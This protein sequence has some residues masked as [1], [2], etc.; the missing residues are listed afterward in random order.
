MI[1]KFA[2]IMGI[3]YLVAGISGFIPP[4]VS[5]PEEVHG[6]V[7]E[8]GYG[9]LLGLF[10]INFL[11]NLVHLAVGV[12]GLMGSRNLAG[13]IIFSRGLALLY[14][15]LTILG[16]I[17]ATNT[18]FGLAPIYGHDVWLHAGSALIAGYFGFFHNRSSAV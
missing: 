11:H 10:P 12:W 4:L 18:L 17:P 3:V 15:V 1:Q 8:A 16:L 13:A 2:L 6:L 5:P 9:R 14:G 7:V